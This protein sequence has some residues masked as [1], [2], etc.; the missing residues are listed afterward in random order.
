[1]KNFLAVIPARRG[2]EGLKNKNFLK[3]NN[4]PLVYWTIKEALKSKHID[5]IVLSSDS[6][7]IKNYCKKFKR[8]EI[9]ERPKNISKNSTSMHD[10][11]KYILKF[12]VKENYKYLIILQPTSP[13]RT[14][15]DIDNSCKITIKNNLD[16]LVSIE[17]LS[18]RYFPQ[19]L[20]KKKNFLIKNFKKNNILINRQN[21][22]NKNK[23][24]ARNGAA[25]YIT[26]IK[27]LKNFILGGKIGGYLM[28]K[29]K[30]IDIN[31]YFDFKMAEYIMKNK[32]LQK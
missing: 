28:P 32:K 29:W 25:I 8:L 20:Y 18:H 4:K 23:F 21:I 24:F 12:Q 17:E 10:L 13:L 2:S 1:M 16:S 22:K 15:D 27:F 26:K 11:L 6:E 19:N 30:N 9:L 5:K 3:F 31:D 14:K 7:K